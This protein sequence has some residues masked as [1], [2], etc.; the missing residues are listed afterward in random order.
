MGTSFARQTGERR[1]LMY[2]IR[3][4]ASAAAQLPVGII[5]KRNRGKPDV[6]PLQ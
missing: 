1:M 3:Q 6:T 5:P 4:A 2:S